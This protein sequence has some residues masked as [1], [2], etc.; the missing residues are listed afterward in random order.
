MKKRFEKL[1]HLSKEKQMF[2]VMLLFVA[3]IGIFCMTGCGEQ[4]C[5]KPSYNNV[6][7]DDEEVKVCSLPGC[8]G[9]LTSGKGC[10]CT[11]WPQSIKYV[12]ATDSDSC[13]KGCDVRYYTKHGCLGCSDYQ[14]DSCYYGCINMKVSKEKFDGEQVTG[15]F[16]GS[17]DPDSE[18]LHRI[19]SEN[20][21]GC[22]D[23]CIVFDCDDNIG[24]K[25][26]I[27]I[28]EDYAVMLD[29]E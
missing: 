6:E 11:L 3:V 12:S 14:E 26:P 23:G 10:S 4:E 24:Q 28:L 16:F 5:E 29:D 8:G 21:I 7:I 27:R 13:L 9:C 18:I 19:Y 17:S 15:I 20:I 1:N 25:P 2:I 22:A